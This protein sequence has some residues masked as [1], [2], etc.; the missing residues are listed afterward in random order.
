MDL[1]TLLLV[2]ANMNTIKMNH[3]RRSVEKQ[4]AVSSLCHI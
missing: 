4:N 3:D 2:K 1:Y